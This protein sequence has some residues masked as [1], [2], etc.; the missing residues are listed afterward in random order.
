MKFVPLIG[1][2]LFSLSFLMA[3]FTHF[4]PQSIGYATASGV[5]MPNILVPASG[6]LA[7]IGALG[8]ILGYKAKLAAWLLVIFLVPVTFIMHKF[9]TLTDPM[10]QQVA[11]AFFIKNLAMLGGA[12]LIAF[13]GA[14][15]VSIDAMK[16]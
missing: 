4:M 9:W 13:F 2:I 10:Q 14:G 7:F 6:I 8:V 16:K 11:M 3:G 5:P 15:P 1:R 12:L